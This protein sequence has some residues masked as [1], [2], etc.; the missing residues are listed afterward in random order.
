MLNDVY[1]NSFTIQEPTIEITLSKDEILSTKAFLVPHIIVDRFLNI[2]T[3]HHRLL[4]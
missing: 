4:K 1:W 3:D 2:K